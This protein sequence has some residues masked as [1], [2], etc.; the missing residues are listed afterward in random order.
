MISFRSADQFLDELLSSFYKDICVQQKDNYDWDR[1]SSDGVDRS[2]RPYTILHKKA[3]LALTRH[4]QEFFDAYSL[5]EDEASKALFIELIRY[6][7]SGHKHVRLSRN[8]DEYKK[9]VEQAKSHPTRYVDENSTE[10]VMRNLR[11]YDLQFEGQRLQLKTLQIL[12]PFLFRQYYFERNGVT[13]RPEKGD[14]VV[15][16]G[17]GLGDTGLAFGA[18]V[19]LSGFVYVFEILKLHIN[20]CKE[21]FEQNPGIS[22]F[23][24]LPYALSDHRKEASSCQMEVSSDL[25]FGFKLNDEDTRFELTTLDC[26]VET[27]ELDRV[28]FIKLDIEGSELSA[29]KGAEATLRRF[30]PKLAISLYHK[31]EDFYEI[32]LYLNNLGLGY[33]FYLDHYTIYV[34]E[35]ILYAVAV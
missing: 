13:I 11:F 29:L 31:C 19:G 24:L 20:V 12:W 35:T 16:G 27:G 28:D 17:A 33:K 2:D 23:K 6:R 9:I 22:R 7:L 34:A 26:L 18:S 25:N 21:N 1:F 15:D 14:Y 30:K 5:L 32:P 10:L 3:L 4:T 8:N